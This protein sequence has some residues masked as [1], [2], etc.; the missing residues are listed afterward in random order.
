[1]KL[2]F[3]KQEL[4]YSCFATCV[5]IILEYYGIKKSE[6]DLRILLKT[7]PS[8]GTLWEIA[9]R[10]IRNLRFELVWKKSWSLE[11]LTPLISQ[12]TPVIADIWSK[13]EADK[14]AVVIV[15]ISENY[16][17]LIDPEYG[18]LV[19]MSKTDFLKLWGKRKNLAGYL[20]HK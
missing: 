3:Y 9:E 16:V 17:T 1:M 11:E 14:H 7:T 10:E 4:W 2:P 15:D 5:K 19:D 8:F 20:K 6:R 12:A 18:E 13:E